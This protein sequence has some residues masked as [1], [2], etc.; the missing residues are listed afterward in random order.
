[1]NVEH[2]EGKV[3]PQSANKTVDADHEDA[4]PREALV[5][6][7]HGVG[8]EEANADEQ[9]GPDEIAERGSRID[10]AIHDQSHAA[11]RRGERDRHS[12]HEVQRHLEQRENRGTRD[13]ENDRGDE[14]FAGFFQREVGERG[15]DQCT[16]YATRDDGRI[17]AVAD[18]VPSHQPVV[19]EGEENAGDSGAD[20]AEQ[21]IKL[22]IHCI[23]FLI[24]RAIFFR[25]G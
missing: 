12:D 3:S 23:S 19:D 5:Q 21:E 15:A 25:F 14:H 9:T 8:E 7:K 13:G 18:H 4:L 16:K 20:G 24:A 17:E 2:H 6:P 22:L 11:E 10:D 1:M